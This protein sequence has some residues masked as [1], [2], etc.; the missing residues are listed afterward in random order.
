MNNDRFRFRAWDVEQQKMVFPIT[1][2]RGNETLVG[3][4][5]MG[6]DT[7]EIIT[8]QCTGL[9][10]SEG[11]LIWEGDVFRHT[12]N[13]LV[14]GKGNAMSFLYS[15]IWNSYK[16]CFALKQLYTGNEMEIIMDYKDLS[17]R[18]ES[19]KVI[20]NIY[21]NPELIQSNDQPTNVKRDDDKD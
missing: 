11:N 2:T 5:G 16:A 18:T 15:V 20:G 13:D 4:Q 10:D 21:E 12:Y 3:L 14:D 8:M 9:K 17:G 1:A 19:V 7:D 6:V